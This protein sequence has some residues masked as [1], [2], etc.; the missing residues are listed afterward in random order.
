M[1]RAGREGVGTD[2]LTFSRLKAGCSRFEMALSEKSLIKAEGGFPR[3]LQRQPFCSQQRLLYDYE[4][5]LGR[6]VPRWLIGSQ[7]A[8]LLSP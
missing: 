1:R 6:F 2:W 7:F 4:A 8:M 5:A 3:T